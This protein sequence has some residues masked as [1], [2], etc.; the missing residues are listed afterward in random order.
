MDTSEFDAAIA[1]AEAALAAT[2]TQMEEARQR[3]A[4]TITDFV[5]PW[6]AEQARLAVERNPDRAK[7]LGVDGIRALKADVAALTDRLPELV[8][9]E[10][11]DAV[12]WAHLE[13]GWDESD[14]WK[15]NPRYNYSAVSQH[16]QADTFDKPL[17]RI[18]GQLGPILEAHGLGKP[19]D[20]RN[21][22]GG[23]A[24]PYYPFGVDWTAEM[25]AAAA[26]YADLY[27]ELRMHN[28]KRHESQAAKERAE[29][30]D[31]WNQA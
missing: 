31:L 8:K 5:T 4:A 24:K 14:P 18:L 3:L 30:Q 23:S 20:W 1:E 21:A 29:A 19:D 7:E 10:L 12:T 13:P 26:Q 15:T 11:L 6:F 27:G 17:R 9:G 22:S 2:R 16:R 28:Q 25:K